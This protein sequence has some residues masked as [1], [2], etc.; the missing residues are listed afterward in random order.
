MGQV[1]NVSVETE[2]AFDH[3]LKAAVQ[4]GGSDPDAVLNALVEEL[5]ITGGTVNFTVSG[6][7]NASVG[8]QSLDVL[9]LP[10]ADPTAAANNAAVG[11][12]PTLRSL[13]GNGGEYSS[14]VSLMEVN[15]GCIVAIEVTV[16]Q[17]GDDGDE[18]E[19]VTLKNIAAAVDPA[20]TYY[21]DGKFSKS[22]LT[23]TASYSNGTTKTLKEDEYKLKIGGAEVTTSYTFN[24]VGNQTFTIEYGGETT[25]VTVNVVQ[26]EVASIEV[27]KKPSKTTYTA[28]DTFSPAGMEVTVTYNSGK[29]ETIENITTN[30]DSGVTWKPSEALTIGNQSV[31]IFYQ[32]QEA[33]VK[34][35]VNPATVTDIE[36]TQNPTKMTYIS[37]ESFNP[38]GMTVSEV[39][40]DG[41]KTAVT[42]YTYSTAPLTKDTTEVTISY[43]GRSTT[44]KVEVLDTEDSY[45]N[46]TYSIAT[47]DGLEF[48]ADLVNGGKTD[49]DITLDKDITLKEEWTPI[50]NYE[51]QYTGTFDGNGKTI[52]GL[53]F[54]QSETNNVGLI[55]SLG[56]NGI[57]RDVK[58]DKVTIKANNNVGGIVGGNRGGSI[59]GC[60]VSGDISG[61]RQ[62]G[63]VVGYFGVGNNVVTACYHEGSVSGSVSV[64]GVAGDSAYGSLT[65]CY[66]AGNVSGSQYVGGVTGY[67]NA[68]LAIVKAC[69]WNGYDGNGIGTGSGEAT[70]VDGAT[71]TWANAVNAMNTAL[72]SAG[73]EWKY[74]LTGELPTLKK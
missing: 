43:G 11:W 35:T 7:N 22:D 23:V 36:V 8:R 2:P 39:Y 55:G 25:T 66:H 59:I 45:Q 48:V 9:F 63:G 13:S 27:T 26:S 10:G 17:P 65:A 62:V 31:T 46:G 16:E 30:G 40:S 74:E 61:A 53:T 33:T 73:S 34:I 37:G 21:T 28:G 70:K 15:G 68:S 6:L 60:S 18:P 42:D 3:A 58:L 1:E 5:G 69:Y 56:E 12:L 29:T 19:P 14:R 47:A 49:I 44:V 38:A 50:G 32:G 41:T 54:K 4:R 20:K 57:V 72:Q 24:S 51:K 71:I 52:T 64:G 67:A